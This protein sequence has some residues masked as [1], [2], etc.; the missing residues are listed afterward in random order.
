MRRPAVPQVAPLIWVIAPRR[1]PERPRPPCSDEEVYL[2]E[3]GSPG[4]P[5]DIKTDDV[6]AGGGGLPATSFFA[7]LC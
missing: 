2:S 5:E 7:R 3:P 6:N 1:H 4:A